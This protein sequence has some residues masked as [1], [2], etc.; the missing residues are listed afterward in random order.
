[1]CTF[2]KLCSVYS[3]KIINTVES[4]INSGWDPSQN[5]SWVSEMSSLWACSLLF[6][7]PPAKAKKPQPKP[8]SLVL[9]PCRAGRAIGLAFRHQNDGNSPP[10]W[11]KWLVQVLKGILLFLLCYLEGVQRALCLVSYLLERIP[12]KRSSVNRGQPNVY[13]SSVLSFCLPWLGE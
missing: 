7:L 2:C 12:Y 11:Q 4:G 5:F 6:P 3:C 1:M 10:F 13:S 9:C 8:F